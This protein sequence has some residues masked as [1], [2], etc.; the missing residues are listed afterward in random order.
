MTPVTTAVVESATVET[1][2]PASVE[3]QEPIAVA[4]PEAATV[5]IPATVTTTAPEVATVA[6]PESATIPAAVPAGGGSSAPTQ[7]FPFWGAAMIAAAALVAA[8]AGSR[9]LKNDN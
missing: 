7:D 2:E 1:Q 4:V 6:V 5:A 3:A 9:L 8:G